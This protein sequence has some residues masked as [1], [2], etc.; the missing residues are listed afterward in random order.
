M[1][2]FQIDIKS[3][4]AIFFV[5]GSN[6]KFNTTIFSQIGLA[7]ARLF[8]F[9]ANFVSPLTLEEY[10]GTDLYVSSFRVS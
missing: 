5:G 6:T 2:Y 1:E 7:V 8:K 3:R 4:K 10:A 9:Y